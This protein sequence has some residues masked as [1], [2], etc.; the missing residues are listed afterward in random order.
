LKI[1]PTQQDKIPRLL[2]NSKSSLLFSQ[3]PLK[4]GR[5]MMMMMMI[6]FTNEVGRN[7]HFPASRW[8]CMTHSQALQ[9]IP[10]KSIAT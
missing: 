7:C 3:K 1:T 8:N 10:G 4:S 9:G 5:M 6:T 2:W